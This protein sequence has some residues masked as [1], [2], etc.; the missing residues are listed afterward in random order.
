[1]DTKERLGYWMGL[2]VKLLRHLECEDD[3]RVRDYLIHIRE[4]WPDY[5]T[6]PIDEMLLKRAADFLRSRGW[7]LYLG[8]SVARPRRWIR[9]S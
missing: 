1:M 4:T 9:K 3:G 7:K 2:T 8:E 5:R 6:C